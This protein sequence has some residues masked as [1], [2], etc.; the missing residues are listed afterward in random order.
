MTPLPMPSIEAFCDRALKPSQKDRCRKV[1]LENTVSRRLW[2]AEVVSESTFLPGFFEPKK[3]L[4]L[5][6]GNHKTSEIACRKGPDSE[7][8][9][10]P[11]SL[12]SYG[13]FNQPGVSGSLAMVVV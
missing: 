7:K 10:W 9:L 5:L 3:S 12:S 1:R 8:K 4:E 13:A 11:R 2:L 6:Q